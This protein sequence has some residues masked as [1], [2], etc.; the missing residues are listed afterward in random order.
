MKGFMKNI[1]LT[2]VLA[3]TVFGACS[4]KEDTL[5][6]VNQDTYY[7]TELQCQTVVN[8]CYIPIQSIYTSD[9]ALLTECTTD[10]MYND[11][12]TVDA[13]L[14][15]SPSKPQFGATVWRQG[16]R[17]VQLCNDAIA[18]ISETPYVN[19]S[20]KNVLTAECR[21]MRA[22]YYY[23]LTNT[24]DGVP[25]YTCQMKTHA[26]QD[27]VRY[28]GR[29]PADTIRVRMYKD[30][31]YNALPYLGGPLKVKT[32]DAPG[33]RSGFAHA[34]ML[35]AK[36]AMWVKDY[37]GALESLRELEKLYGTF[38]PDDNGFG[39]A[40]PIENIKWSY[41]GKEKN[42]AIFE[43]QHEY[44]ISGIKKYSNLAMI[45]MPPRGTDAQTGKFLWNGV[46][47]GDKYG[48]TMP[49]RS[50]TIV[51]SEFAYFRTVKDRN[52][53]DANDDKN[54]A[55]PYRQLT[56]TSKGCI[57]GYMN[58]P[59]KVESK[60]ERDSHAES[61]P[62]YY[63]KLDM[64]KY[65]SG[66]YDKRAPLNLALGNFET[67]QAFNK[68]KTDGVFYVGEK[69]W[70]PNIL[71]NYD[72]NN[73]KIFRYADALLMMAECYYELG[74]ETMARNYLDMVRV[75]AGIGRLGTTTN[76]KEEI[77]RERG[78]ELFGEYQRKWDLVRWGVWYDRTYKYTAYDKLRTH[79]RR[80][81]E[82]YPIPDQQCALSDYKLDNPAYASE[83]L[84]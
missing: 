40:Y 84:N 29:T 81:H 30:L 48:N 32:A 25:Y 78:K 14:E 74:D 64:D 6:F 75:R 28:L 22:M 79:M 80:C 11:N 39:G 62:Y 55:D 47:F 71:L 70:C 76:F 37:E 41:K 7:R 20:I 54:P 73:Y 10:L 24:F 68:L 50:V 60:E 44:D 38:S 27:S 63:V 1:F 51:N 33:R 69:F 35:M 67:G 16:Y 21:I 53:V 82:Y 77:I 59:L 4:L 2:V 8:G 49:G 3:L 65:R 45:M 19:D 61:V 12:S 72:A 83:G 52:D 18:T 42:E 31:K 23:I 5:P 26:V 17:G 15:V 46:D 36:F 66:D 43:I 34:H 56:G 9:F 13:R 58:M 57:F